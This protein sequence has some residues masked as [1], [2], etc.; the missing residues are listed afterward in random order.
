MPRLG[1]IVEGIVLVN[2][3]FGGLGQARRCKKPRRLPASRI[4][5]TLAQSVH[6]DVGIDLFFVWRGIGLF[7]IS[8][9]RNLVWEGKNEMY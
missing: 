7:L 9:V 5:A 6:L 3:G 4:N 2:D 1:D 8:R